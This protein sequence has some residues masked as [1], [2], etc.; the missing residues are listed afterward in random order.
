[1]KLLE[2]LNNIFDISIPAFISQCLFGYLFTQVS[3]ALENNVVI[4]R[5]TLHVLLQ[6]TETPCDSGSFSQVNK[7]CNAYGFQSSGFRR[8][9]IQN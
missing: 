5:A 8:L 6:Y 3:R 4:L 1:M 2:A 7:F 9:R